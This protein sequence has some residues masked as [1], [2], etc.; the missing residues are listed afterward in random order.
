MS[1][2][3]N[4]TFSKKIPSGIFNVVPLIGSKVFH[5]SH[6]VFFSYKIT[7]N[8]S[9]SCCAAPL[10]CAQGR[11]EWNQRRRASFQDQEEKHMQCSGA[12]LRNSISAHRDPDRNKK[13]APE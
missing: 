10:L 13:S 7:S 6:I 9:P 8:G 4:I 11:E 5:F 2:F 3:G 12:Q 1:T